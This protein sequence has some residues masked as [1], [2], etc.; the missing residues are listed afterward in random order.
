MDTWRLGCSSGG[1]EDVFTTNSGQ[2]SE[3]LLIDGVVFSICVVL[4]VQR[5]KNQGND[6]LLLK[7]PFKR[8]AEEEE[9]AKG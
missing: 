1:H 7:L 6:G 4:G 5:V 9:P 3:L 2:T 8:W